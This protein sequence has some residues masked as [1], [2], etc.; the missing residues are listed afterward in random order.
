M[1][2]HTSKLTTGQ[3]KSHKWNSGEN[4]T[5]VYQN[6]WETLRAVI[7]TWFIALNAYNGKEECIKSML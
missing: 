5:T 6:L 7:Q 3:R 2:Q 1:K 4:E